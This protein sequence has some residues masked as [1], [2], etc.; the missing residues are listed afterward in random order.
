[1]TERKKGSILIDI[2][3]SAFEVIQVAKCRQCDG[4]KYY[5]KDLET[6][7]F[8]WWHEAEVVGTEEEVYKGGKK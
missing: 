2:D 4:L 3:S 8:G 6:G 5:G 7:V 1:M